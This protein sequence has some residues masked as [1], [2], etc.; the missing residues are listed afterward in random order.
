[1]SVARSRVASFFLA[2]AP[3]AAH[4]APAADGSPRSTKAP[5]SR[6]RTRIPTRTGSTGPRGDRAAPRADEGARAV[7][8][9][10]A[11]EAVQLAQALA[12]ALAAR[13]RRCTGVVCVWDDPASPGPPVREPAAGD[14]VAAAL[15]PVAGVHVTVAGRGLRVQLPVDPVAAVAAHL[16][17]VYAVEAAAAVVLALCG[18]RPPCFDDILTRQDHIVLALPPGAPMGLAGLATAS[19]EQFVSADR[20]STVVAANAGGPLPRALRNRA[21][22]RKILEAIP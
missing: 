6:K 22:V 17:C 14:R 19:L 16:D 4:G 3:V 1:M 15:T 20:L 21:P 5:R 7:A 13:R 12:A 9:V 10:G 2:P 11:G 18:P 8:V